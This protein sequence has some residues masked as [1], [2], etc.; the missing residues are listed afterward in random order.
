MLSVRLKTISTFISKEDRV[1]DIGCDHALLPI[2]L[3]KNNICQKVMATDV[4]RNALENA[5]KNIENAGLTKEIPTV[6]SDG[7]EQIK[8]EDF[9][10]IILAGMGSST[11]LKIVEKI[12]KEHIKKLIIQS[13]NDLFLL[14]V[15]L[16]KR[17][18][19]LQEEKV[20]YE[21]GHYYVIGKYSLCKSKLSL[22]ELLFGKYNSDYIS[23]YLYLNQKMQTIVKS[24]NCK[25]IT[26][27]IKIMC[28]M[29]L[30]K[31]YL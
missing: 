18:Y 19:Y 27:K 4:N 11:I 26:K 17:K 21:K 25:N 20:V 24:I 14:R 15:T 9:N 6:L 12:K 30:L 2:Y 5:R 16:K 22:R 7:L 10:T 13:N 31:K 1:V 3:L 29:K 28:K 23:Y 8:Q